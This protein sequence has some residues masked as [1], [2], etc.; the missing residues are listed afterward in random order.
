MG[1]TNAQ[2]VSTSVM[3]RMVN[4]KYS[5]IRNRKINVRIFH[6]MAVLTT[7]SLFSTARFEW[8]VH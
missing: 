8:L 2:T 3:P 6:F 1:G 7:N 4:S 5:K